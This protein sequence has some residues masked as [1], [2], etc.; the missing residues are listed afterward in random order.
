M[1]QFTADTAAYT[2]SGF[3]VAERLTIFEVRVLLP[4]CGCEAV[5]QFRYRAHLHDQ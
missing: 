1:P 3:G 5:D 4:E 2:E